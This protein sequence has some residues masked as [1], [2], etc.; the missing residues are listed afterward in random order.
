MNEIKK[1]GNIVFT[2]TCAF[3]ERKYNEHDADKFYAEMMASRDKDAAQAFECAMTYLQMRIDHC[4]TELEL[5]F[6]NA[7]VV[8]AQS[9]HW[10]GGHFS[11]PVYEHM[12]DAVSNAKCWDDLNRLQLQQVVRALYLQRSCSAPKY[13][14]GVIKDLA[15]NIATELLLCKMDSQEGFLIEE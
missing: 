9:V 12:L 11:V 4:K 5:N 8:S 10:K 3:V 15:F 7:E 13:F 6:A 14:S 1:I 2:D